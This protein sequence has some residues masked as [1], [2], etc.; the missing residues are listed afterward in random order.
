VQANGS[1]ATIR[2]G[3]SVVMGNTN[4]GVLASNGGT[5]LSYKNNQVDGNGNNGT[6]ITPVG[7]VN[8]AAGLN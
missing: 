4:V 3:S 6:P 7:G 2:I 1:G 5:L 8:E